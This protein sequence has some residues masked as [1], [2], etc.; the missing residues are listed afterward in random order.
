M[1]KLFVLF[2]FCCKRNRK[3][4]VSLSLCLCLSFLSSPTSPLSRFSLPPPPLLVVEPGDVEQ[5]HVEDDG[6]RRG[7]PRPPRAAGEALGEGERARD[8]DPPEAA[9]AHRLDSLV[10]AG[11]DLVV[12]VFFDGVG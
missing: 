9:G 5:L 1:L 6:A 4:S 11:D 10:E 12:F 8:V 7:H 2:L 3:S